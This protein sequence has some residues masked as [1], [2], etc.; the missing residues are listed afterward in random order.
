MVGVSS[1]PKYEI[2]EG[3]FCCIWKIRLFQQPSGLIALLPGFFFSHPPL[4]TFCENPK[5][6][7]T[8]TL[9]TKFFFSHFVKMLFTPPKTK[10]LRKK[11]YISSIDVNSDF[12]ILKNAEMTSKI[13]RPPS[14]KVHWVPEPERGGKLRVLFVFLL[15]LYFDI[16]FIVANVGKLRV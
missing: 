12:L 11:R 14:K 4:F 8:L 16:D 6:L 7:F 3:R 2:F 15:N 10:Y 5:F 1:E 9:Q 13:A